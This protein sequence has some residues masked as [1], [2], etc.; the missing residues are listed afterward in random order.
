MLAD[1]TIPTIEDEEDIYISLTGLCEYFTRAAISVKNETDVADAKS[2]KYSMGLR[3][4]MFT[5]AEEFVTLGKFEAQRR[6]ID[7][8]EDLLKMIDKYKGDSVE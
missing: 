7:S 8:P 4:M 2:K 5:V 6:M 3:D 1:G